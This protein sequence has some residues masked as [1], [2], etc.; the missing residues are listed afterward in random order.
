MHDPVVMGLFLQLVACRPGGRRSFDSA[1]RSRLGAHLA[2]TSRGPCGIGQRVPPRGPRRPH[3]TRATDSGDDTVPGSVTSARPSIRL[4][5]QPVPSRREGDAAANAAHAPGGER[6]VVD[7]FTRPAEWHGR[8]SVLLRRGAPCRLAARAK[9]RRLQARARRSTR[10]PL[11][12]GASLAR[13]ARRARRGHPAGHSEV[14]RKVRSRGSSVLIWTILIVVSALW[15][16]AGVATR[17]ALQRGVAPYG[18]TA[19]RMTVAS[20]LLLAYLAATR[21]RIRLSSHLVGDGA[22]MALTHVVL[23]SVCS[24][25]RSNTY[26]RVPSVSCT[27]SCR[28]RRLCGC[29]CSWTPSRLEE[30]ASSD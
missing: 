22:V 3:M 2:G 8:T 20:A 26:L 16:T 24:R 18:L 19:L 21:K 7:A 15:G 11:R 10:E 12:N 13:G 23:P 9:T 6:H 4:L 27:R 29:A 14:A 1:W 25:P 17:A 28:P 5:V 30:A